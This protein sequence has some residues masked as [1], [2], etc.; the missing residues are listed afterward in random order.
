MSTLSNVFKSI[1]KHKSAISAG[2]AVVGVFVTSYLSG[3]AAVEVD[4]LIDPDMDRK[5]KAKVYAK[6]YWKTAVSALVT[7]GCIIGCHK[8][9]VQTE[10]GLA[11]ALAVNK[12]KFLE[13][14][15]KAKE[16]FG[17]EAMNDIYR[18]MAEEDVREF[19]VVTEDGEI[20]GTIDS[21]P[22]SEKTKVLYLYDPI[23]GQ[24]I[25]T[26]YVKILESLLECNFRLQRDYT[27]EFNVFLDY[28]GG[29]CTSD[30]ACYVW[31]F[32]DATQCYDCGYAEEGFVI[33]FRKETWDQIARWMKSGKQMTQADAI[34][35]NYVI[36][37]GEKLPWS[38]T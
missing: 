14:R 24:V 8:S 10:L 18:E 26:T 35:I 36:V 16:K 21:L 22:D 28:I 6:A 27:V 31:D 13:L 38:L 4:H 2:V 30:S 12:D 15:E 9:H 32:D 7:S 20:M 25:P 34:F 33:S 5:L 19:A 3:K 11:A 1:G 37:P 17:E 23:S 29:E